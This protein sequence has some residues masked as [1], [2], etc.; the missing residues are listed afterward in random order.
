MNK[1]R[2]DKARDLMLYMARTDKNAGSRLAHAIE[3][4]CEA[5]NGAY[6]RAA[7]QAKKTGKDVLENWRMT[8]EENKETIGVAASNACWFVSEAIRVL[9]NGD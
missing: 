1:T 7:E 2:M 8:D 4:Y 9:K 6:E 3:F 5:E